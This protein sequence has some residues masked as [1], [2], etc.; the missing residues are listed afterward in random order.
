[1]RLCPGYARV[2]GRV[3][4]VEK[5]RPARGPE[6]S[7]GPGPRESEKS[8]V[9]SKEAKDPAGDGI[10]LQPS[11]RTPD[12]YTCWVHLPHQEPHILH[13]HSGHGEE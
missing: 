6:G 1:M 2:V 8:R 10:G 11:K 9:V 5:P 7:L 12:V 4:S 13:Q 3:L